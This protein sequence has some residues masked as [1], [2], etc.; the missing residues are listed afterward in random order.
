M[1]KDSISE[2]AKEH[3]PVINRKAHKKWMGLEILKL[4]ENRRKVKADRKKYRE[5]DK[6]VKKKCNEAKEEWINMQCREIEEH[7][8]FDSKLMHEKIK[9]VTGK[10]SSTKTGCIKSRDGEILMEKEGILNRW[11]EYIEELYQ[12]DRGPPPHIC[13]QDG[14]LIMED[15]VRHVVRKMK[16]I[17]A[18]GPDDISSEMITA[19]DEVGINTVTKLLNNLYDTGEIPADMKKSIYIAIPKKPGTTDCDQH[20][21][22]S[23]MSHLTKVLLRILM[24]RMR[25]K[26]SQKY[27]KRNLD[28]W[29]TKAQEMPSSH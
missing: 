8:N 1:M 13:N 11:S 17:K 7:A 29:R 5:L 2:A 23:L 9:D 22:I 25:I 16:S 20:R 15:E 27:Q 12:D 26:Y 4:M 24:K 21:T 19:L 10:R 18:P 6:L 3:I 28:S 14:N